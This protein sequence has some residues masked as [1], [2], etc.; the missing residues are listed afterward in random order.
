MLYDAYMPRSLAQDDLLAVAS[1]INVQIQ[2]GRISLTATGNDNSVTLYLRYCFSLVI[3]FLFS[4]QL[5]RVKFF[6]YDHPRLYLYIIW[7]T[8]CTTQ[9]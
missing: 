5:N 3:T 9:Y 2:T 1:R 6:F 7:I 8:V 4:T